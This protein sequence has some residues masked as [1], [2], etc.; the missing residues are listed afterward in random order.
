MP[1]CGA[2]LRGLALVLLACTAAG[3]AAPRAARKTAARAQGEPQMRPLLTSLFIEK[4]F[5]SGEPLISQ[6]EEGNMGEGELHPSP[7][8]AVPPVTISTADGDVT[9]TP[10]SDCSILFATYSPEDEIEAMWSS[11]SLA[12]LFS[13][14]PA[15]AHVVFAAADMQEA[16]LP[17]KV[18][19]SE[20]AHVVFVAVDMA[21]AQVS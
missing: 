15:R 18:H 19:S 9:L 6:L 10:G 7:Y 11:A 4:R 14:L 17:E 20:K 2:L 16:Q 13:E 1:R 3:K 5:G 12:S 21:E 8:S